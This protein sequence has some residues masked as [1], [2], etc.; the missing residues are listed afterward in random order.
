[1]AI[2]TRLQSSE[3][4]E[5]VFHTK[6]NLDRLQQETLPAVEQ[7]LANKMDL[8]KRLQAF[9]DYNDAARTRHAK[10]NKVRISK[11]HFYH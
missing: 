2:A 3:R 1:M 7:I 5:L 6:S 8:F 4:R 11:V 9:C 10:Q